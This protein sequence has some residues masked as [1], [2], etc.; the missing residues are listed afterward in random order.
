VT[1]VPLD[2]PSS[3]L[4]RLRACVPELAS[5]GAKVAAF[6]FCVACIF[7]LARPS[8]SFDA[9]LV[10]SFATGITSWLLIDGGRFFID[11]DSPYGFPR[12]WRG[13][14]L[15]FVGVCTGFFL[16][17]WAGD[18]Y[19]GRSTFGLIPNQPRFFL[20]LFLLTA[21]MG[22]GVSYYFYSMGKS[23]YLARELDTARLQ[24]AQ[25]RLSLLQS[26]LEPHML[27]NTL[28]NL[29][30]LIATDPVRAQAMLDHLIDYLRSTLQASRVTEHALSV[31]FERLR[32][33]LELMA[34]R[35]GA[36]L[37]YTLDLPTALA[38]S[39]VPAL[40][41]QPLVE[42]A[43]KHGLEPKI[44]G[45][46]IT[47]SARLVGALVTLQVTDNGVGMA[48]DHASNGFGLT[49]VRERL[50][51]AFGALGAIEIGAAAA[52]NTWVRVT[53]P[54]NSCTPLR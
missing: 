3:T 16:G 14:A 24:A 11:R 45:G 32:D 35:M 51:T 50:A 15:I 13:V 29:R 44:E 52:G 23:Q 9:Q 10:Y 21:G 8:Q 20:Y 40:L 12:G 42:N 6:C 2:A 17:T 18:A 33:Y 27:F 53:F 5:H 30:A 34:I 31:E 4:A 49:Q 19:T 47:V 1:S 36:R 54:L 7:W 38:A 43:I 46:H 41:L 25:A 26:Q 37:S 48:A 39:Q 28:A 22:A